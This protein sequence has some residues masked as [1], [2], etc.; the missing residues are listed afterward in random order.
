MSTAWSTTRTSEPSHPRIVPQADAQAHE[1]EHHNADDDDD[2]QYEPSNTQLD[3]FISFVRRRKAYLL[4]SLGRYDEAK[5][6]LTAMLK[7]PENS[8]FALNELAYIQK[9]K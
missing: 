2:E 4:V 1:R 3:S 6:I 5:T 9:N 8:D 7:E